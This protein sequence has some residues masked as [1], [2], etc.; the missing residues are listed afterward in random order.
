MWLTAMLAVA[1]AAPL[2]VVLLLVSNLRELDAAGY[3]VLVLL[4][5]ATLLLA[6]FLIAAVGKIS[7]G[8]R[9]AQE[10][11]P[12]TRTWR[13]IGR[14]IGRV[15][16]QVGTRPT[17]SSYTWAAYRSGITMLVVFLLFGLRCISLLQL[18][19]YTY[20]FL[21][22]RQP[23]TNLS[24]RSDVAPWVPEWYW[25]IVAGLLTGAALPPS[26]V[27]G[28]PPGVVG[29]VSL[30]FFL[31]ASIWLMYYTL[32]RLFSEGEYTIYHP[33]EYIVLVPF[34]FIIHA[35]TMAILRQ[36]SPATI[37]AA[38]LNLDL[39]GVGLLPTIV[40]VTYFAVFV[41]AV[42]RAVPEERIDHRKE[43]V[44]IGI[45]DVV[46]NRLIG[47][48]EAT[49]GSKRIR[50]G[51]VTLLSTSEHEELKDFRRE[52]Y[53]VVTGTESEIVDFALKTG[54]PTIVATPPDSHWKYVRSLL[55][56][57]VHVAVEKPVT[58][59]Q[60]EHAEIL[61]VA[62]S[63]E[64]AKLFGL[65]YYVLEKSLP[66]TY[67]LDPRPVYS[68]F[69]E[70]DSPE[71]D[72]PNG[73]VPLPNPK[74]L[75]TIRESLGRLQ[76]VTVK[77]LETRIHS[78]VDGKRL[79]TEDYAHGGLPKETFFHCAMIARLATGPID[80]WSEMRWLFGTYEPRPRE[81]A[82]AHGFEMS[83]T[84]AELSARSGAATLR[85]VAGKYIR[86]DSKSR[87]ALLEYERGSVMSDFNHRSCTVKWAEDTVRIKVK[88]GPNYAV[89]LEMFR[90]LASVPP[91]E[92]GA[93]SRPSRFDRLHEQ[94][95]ILD[96]LSFDPR[97]KRNV[98]YGD[99]VNENTLPGLAW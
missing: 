7:E 99:E 44:V 45:G 12:N 91:S 42:L 96:W 74:E 70:A 10:K 65:S 28:I 52:G 54:N 51:Q 63:A 69:L 40:G 66:L 64:G 60:S 27:T 3:F 53:H 84:Y 49:Q 90:D 32:F 93:K 50:A 29:I 33:L 34:T 68:G 81:I 85:L 43:L 72:S 39:K 25:F 87:T 13:A 20:R 80:Q 67:L 88:E 56:A 89:Q 26:P 17:T 75:A 86:D 19:K 1:L 9:K 92:L 71:N 78:P 98:E 35:A 83:P 2:V 94:V 23:T 95:E 97:H 73:P 61:R 11:D 4:I 77:L 41:G 55:A 21:G 46:Q 18:S 5:A 48:I 47:A 76:S 38:M 6:L 15:L 59:I 79:W 31:E 82:H 16:D 62:D 36:L 57:G 8:V 14:E 58:S 22:P 37:V 24:G 30:Y